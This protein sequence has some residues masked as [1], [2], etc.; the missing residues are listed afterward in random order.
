MGLYKIINHYLEKQNGDVAPE[1][2]GL[3]LRA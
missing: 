2:L 1:L 3:R